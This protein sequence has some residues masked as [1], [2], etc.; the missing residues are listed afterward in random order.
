MPNRLITVHERGVCAAVVLGGAQV[1]HYW[2][3]TRPSG[4]AMLVKHG[5]CIFGFQ[6]RCLILRRPTLEV[7]KCHGPNGRNACTQFLR[8]AEQRTYQIMSDKRFGE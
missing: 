1:R 3:I 6:Y 4:F 7:G 8:G 2:A 5:V